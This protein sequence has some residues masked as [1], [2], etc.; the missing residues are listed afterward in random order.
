MIDQTVYAWLACSSDVWAV[1]VAPLALR[2]SVARAPSTTSRPVAK[3]RTSLYW[4]DVDPAADAAG[5]S[6]AVS[7][8]AV[9]RIRAARRA[10]GV[11]RIASAARPRG[12]PCERAGVSDA[13]TV[14][15]RARN[16][17]SSGDVSR[18]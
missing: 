10:T 12:V 11:A 8:T 1:N 13:A 16:A 14:E 15:G 5:A 3:A 2:T 6:G 4:C 9:A 7:A 18:A 17:T